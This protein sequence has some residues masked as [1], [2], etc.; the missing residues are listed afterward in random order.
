MSYGNFFHGG[1]DGSSFHKMLKS[2]QDAIE[3]GD[4]EAANMLFHATL[5]AIAH[6]LYGLT[7][8]VGTEVK[9]ALHGVGHT[10]W[11]NAVCKVWVTFMPST[12][13]DEHGDP[14]AHEDQDGE[15]FMVSD[16]II[17]TRLH[18]EID[19]AEFPAFEAAF[20]QAVVGALR[21]HGFGASWNDNGTLTM[22]GHVSHM[23]QHI[24]DQVSKFGDAIEKELGESAPDPETGERKWW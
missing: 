16:V 24:E 7:R 10:Q 3:A 23:D 2:W 1:P 15:K 11:A 20:N 12:E 9:A 4:R 13:M 18:Q 21:A 17:G 6:Q 19:E 5:A 8:E 22:R 14:V